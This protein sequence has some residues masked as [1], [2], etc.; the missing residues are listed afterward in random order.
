MNKDFQAVLDECLNRITLGGEQAVGACMAE[1]PAA[2]TELEPLLRLAVGLKVLQADQPPPP[3]TLQAGRQKLLRETARLREAEEE[4]KRSRRGLFWFTLPV[5]RRSMTVAVLAAL[6]VVSVLGGGT[7][8]AS[9]TS[10]PG[11]ALYGVKRM[12]EQFQL[13]VTWDQEAKADLQQRLDERRRAE[14]IAIAT[15]QRIAEMSFRGRVESMG[16][17]RWTVGG[18]VVSTS[19][20]TVMDGEIGVGTLV[21]IQVRSFSDGTLLAVSISAEPEQT[22][23]E[24]T[25]VPTAEPTMTAT[26]VPP[27]PVPT[28]EEIKP[29][30]PS[31]VV[32]TEEPAPSATPTKEPTPKPTPTASPT[33]T[34]TPVPPTPTPPRDIKVRFSGR[35]EAM[36]GGSWTVGGQAVR[37]DAAT[38]IDESEERAAVGATA[39]VLAIRQEDGSLLAVE[40]K[41]EPPP[42]V[43]DQPFEF[44][45][46]IESWSATQW[47][48][49][50]HALRIYA[51]TLIQGRPQNG[52]LAEVKAVLQSDG[53]I[54]AKQI[55]VHPPTEEVQFEGVI[56]AIAAGEW[57]IEGVTVRI[58][59]DTAIVGTPA[60]GYPAE[61][62]GLLLPDGSVLG[63]RIVVQ[64]LPG[65]VT[66]PTPTASL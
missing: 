13:L 27:T 25:P 47:V 40:I 51:D 18:V 9:A 29:T 3:V 2:A 17:A 10:L 59:A 55:I 5:M 8:A 54:L 26:E 46:L 4:K 23:P 57:V 22:V 58:D 32:P 12:T 38:R 50:G 31:A 35:I 65:T 48:V 43:P 61:V 28:V 39:T 53:T 63:R 45:G 36:S 1:Y 30:A 33:S 16:N 24:P 49:A 52:L 7:I 64:P 14:A 60:V 21:R 6:L 42:P 19:A 20:E 37:T 44:Q 66:E 62:M 56:Q 15:S 41:I 11:D 34:A